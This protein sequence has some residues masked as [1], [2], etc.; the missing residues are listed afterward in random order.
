[1]SE[2]RNDKLAVLGV[3]SVKRAYGDGTLLKT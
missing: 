3:A 2:N 1:M